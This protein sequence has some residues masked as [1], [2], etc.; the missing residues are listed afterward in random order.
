[1][2]RH[3][4][5]T[6]SI[7][8]LPFAVRCEAS[9]EGSL[10]VASKQLSVS[11]AQAILRDGADQM[12]EFVLVLAQRGIDGDLKTRVILCHPDWD[13]PVELACIESNEEGLKVELAH[14]SSQP[15]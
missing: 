14:D 12:W 1:M 11:V 8:R 7:H 5:Q 10:S 9:P 2:I 4:A 6:T 15:P 13:D 3:P